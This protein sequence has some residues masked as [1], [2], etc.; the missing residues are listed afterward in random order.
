MSR[1]AGA[2]VKSRSGRLDAI[3]VPASRPASFLQPAIDLAAMLDVLF[4][5][6]CSK[7]TQVEQVAQRIANTPGARCLIVPVPHEWRHAAIFPT[8]NVA[9]GIHGG[10]R[11][12]TA[13]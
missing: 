13:T 12:R 11:R 1:L 7:Q 10:E 5:V 3:I 2:P 6:L 9:L 4:V 8:P